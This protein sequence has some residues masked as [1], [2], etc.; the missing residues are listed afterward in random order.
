MGEATT[1]TEKPKHPHECDLCPKPAYHQV[2][3]QELGVWHKYCGECKETTDAENR[4]AT[5]K[6]RRNP[7][8]KKG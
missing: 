7:R 8:N 4:N 6:Q 2:W 1:V 5:P 3:D